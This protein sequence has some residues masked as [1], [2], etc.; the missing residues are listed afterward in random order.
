MNKGYYIERT[1][2][3]CGHH[4]RLE[5][6]KRESAFSLKT[7]EG[8]HGDE[9]NQCSGRKFFG[10]HITPNLDFELLKEWA[11]DL[12]LF[13]MEQDEELFLSRE[14]YIDI[15]L[16]VL[17]T[18]EVKDHK[19]N[20]LMDSLC[21]IV[22]DNSVEGNQQKNEKL[23]QRV[24]VEL[25]KRKDKLKLAG[26]WIMDYIKEVVYPQLNLNID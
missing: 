10:K 2:S 5:L 16:K 17:D 24:L 8:I 15:V 20:V 11:T 9:C 26:D 1:C 18:V 13:L 19:R 4:I 21:I 14:E 22:Y 7:V 3:K 23:K 12:N 25:N 6:T